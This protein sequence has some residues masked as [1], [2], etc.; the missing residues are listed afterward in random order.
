MSLTNS[1]ADLNDT[2]SAEPAAAQARYKERAVFYVPTSSFKAA[3]PKVPVHTF[4][5]ERQEALREDGPS[6][7]ILLDLSDKLGLSFPATLPNVLARYVRLSGAEPLTLTAEATSVVY[8]VIAGEGRSQFGHEI[9]TW[10]TGDVFMLPGVQAATHH[11]TSKRAL[12]YALSDEPLLKYAGLFPRSDGPAA[13]GAVLYTREEIDRHLDIQYAREAD[14]DDA[15]KAVIFSTASTRGFGTTTPVLTVNV[16]TLPAGADQRAHRHNPAA[17]TL[18]VDGDDVYSVVD[19]TRVDW[20][21]SGVLVTPPGALHSHHSRGPKP[22]RSIVVQDSGIFF[23]AR[24]TG[25]RFD[26]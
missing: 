16:N 14:P 21:P 9:L 11:A 5:Q 26:N 22:M 2:E 1:P 23:H 20:Q 24:I 12:L 15:G 19:D 6:A 18:S 10:K 17:L 4:E 3:P 13:T 7:V 8:Y 25:F